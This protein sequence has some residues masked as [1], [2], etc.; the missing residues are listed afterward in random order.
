M[1]LRLRSQRH[2]RSTP[3]MGLVRLAGLLGLDS[4]PEVDRVR[5]LAARA[6]LDNGDVLAACDVMSAAV[7][8]R[9]PRRPAVAGGNQGHEEEDR[10][11]FAPELCDVLQEVLGR[12]CDAGN[13]GE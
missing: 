2:G 3:G 8:E 10:H 5:A 13:R 11:A 12:G 9:P 4:T 1:P 6:A 7:L